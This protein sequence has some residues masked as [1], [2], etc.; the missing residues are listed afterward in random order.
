[1]ELPQFAG[2][3]GGNVAVFVPVGEQVPFVV[4]LFPS[5][6]I[7]QEKAVEVPPV[8]LDQGAAADGRVVTLGGLVQPL[9]DGA[10]QVGRFGGRGKGKSGGKGLGK[11]PQVGLRTPGEKLPAARQVFFYRQGRD[12]ALDD[13]QQQGVFLFGVHRRGCRFFFSGQRYGIFA[14][15]REIGREERGGGIGKNARVF[16]YIWV[17]ARL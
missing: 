3:P 9:P 7:H 12:V 1:M 8:V 17:G 11:D 13:V 10:S 15:L 6:G 2:V 4:G 16:S 14:C 5:R